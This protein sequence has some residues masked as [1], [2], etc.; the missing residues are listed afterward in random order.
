MKHITLV[1]KSNF[2]QLWNR[3]LTVPCCMF[4]FLLLPS[5]LAFTDPVFTFIEN[6]VRNG[7]SVLVITL[8]WGHCMCVCVCVIMNIRGNWLPTVSSFPSRS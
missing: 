8:L 3:A 2:A 1:E 5:F 7:E 6:A 4:N